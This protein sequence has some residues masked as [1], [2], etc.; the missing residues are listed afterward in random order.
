MLN[1]IKT[2]ILD[3]PI[4]SCILIFGLCLVFRIIE[5]LILKTDE[6]ILAENFIH[7]IIGILILFIILKIINYKFSD[8]GFSKKGILKNVLCGIGLGTICFFIAYN[9]EYIVL[10]FMGKIPMSSV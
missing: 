6:T 10:V 2:Y 9:V 5:Y 4:R 3:K 7:K 1:K 8:I